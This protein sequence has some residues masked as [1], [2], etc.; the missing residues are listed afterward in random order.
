[1]TETVLVVGA[2]GHIGAPV[3]ERLRANGFD[4]RLFVRDLIRARAR[5]GEGFAYATGE[6]NDR[7]SLDRALDGCTAVHVSLGGGSDSDE[8]DRVEHRG[9]ALVADRAARHGLTRVTY[10]SGDY[11]GTPE[12]ERLPSER[13]K[14]QAEACIR[15]SGVPYTIFRPTYFMDTLP[16]HVQGRL[17]VVLGRQPHRLHM[18]AAIDFGEMVSASLRTSDAANRVLRVR[19][20]EPISIPE[21]LGTYCSIAAPGT[22]VVSVPLP[23]MATVDRVFLGRKLRRTLDTMRLLQRLGERGDASET[24][25]LLAPA[26]TTVQQWCRRAL[27]AEMRIGPTSERT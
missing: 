11:V 6:V 13:A 24:E 23:I 17:A 16:R 8:I 18:V 14:A 26:T 19:G 25:G 1:M 7:S 22:R 12:G 21:A 4:V 5:F 2:T 27:S 15:E 10:L 9:T 20:P 3:A